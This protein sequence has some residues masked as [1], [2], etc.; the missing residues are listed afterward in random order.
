MFFFFPFLCV[1]VSTGMPSEK[2]VVLFPLPGLI[3]V[4]VL[5]VAL[6]DMLRRD[7]SPLC[8]L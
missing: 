2:W 7:P 4:R 1:C 8:D 6:G 3:G 5:C